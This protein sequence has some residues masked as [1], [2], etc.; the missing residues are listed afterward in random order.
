MITYRVAKFLVVLACCNVLFLAG[1]ANFLK[2]EIG[3]I[4]R[5]EARIDLVEGGVQDAIWNTKDL[6]L[7]YSYSEVENTF[8]LSGKLVFDRSLT[9]SFRLTKRFVVKMSFLDG[10]GRVL[11]TVDI[12]P[13]ISSFGFDPDPEFALKR[14][15]LKPMGS[16]SIAFNYYGEFMGNDRESRGDSWDIF[17]FPFD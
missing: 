7:T 15:C 16:R 8:S 17:Y 1:C 13:L 5:Q 10:E 12:S 2:P 9:D 14:S 11:E 4:A 3:A 6:E